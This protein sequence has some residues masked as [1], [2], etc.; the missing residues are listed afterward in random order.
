VSYIYYRI[1]RFYLQWGDKT[2]DVLATAVIT[3]VHIC[4]ILS[5]ILILE[6]FNQIDLEFTYW[7][8]LPIAIIYAF[9]Y[10]LFKQ[11]YSKSAAK[12]DEEESTTRDLKG[13]GIWL[14]IIFSIVL[15]FYMATKIYTG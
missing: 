1:Y 9:Y 14:Y 6:K 8:I 11:S 2:P 15:P 12:W 5:I 7:V 10:H 3:A 4:H 13:A